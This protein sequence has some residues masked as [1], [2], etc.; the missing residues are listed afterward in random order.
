M[1]AADYK[2]ADVTNGTH[3]AVAKQ[4][5]AH[6][7]P[8]TEFA[9]K[10]YDLE[11]LEIDHVAEK[12]LVRKLDLFIVPPVMLLYLFVCRCFQC[13]TFVLQVSRL[14]HHSVSRASWTESTSATPASTVW[15]TTW[16]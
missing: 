2:P 14:T 15:K 11:T 10:R 7:I 6:D 4:L 5:R 1:D 12:K 8:P 13:R 3:E 9:E 16:T